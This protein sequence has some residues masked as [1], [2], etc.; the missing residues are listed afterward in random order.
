[1]PVDQLAVALR[2]HRGSQPAD[3]L[4]GDQV[5]SDWWSLSGATEGRVARA[6]ITR[7]VYNA[8][9]GDNIPTIQFKLTTWT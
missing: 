6:T 4:D 5:E 3:G 1:M 7:I 9:I 8:G 2:G